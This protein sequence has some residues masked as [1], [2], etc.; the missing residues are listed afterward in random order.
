MVPVSPS[1]REMLDGL[2]DS[3]HIWVSRKGPMTRSALQMA[4]LQKSRIRLTLGT[5]R[6]SVPIVPA[7]RTR[8]A[9]LE[10]GLYKHDVQR[11][12]YRENNN[13]QI[14]GNGPG[15]FSPSGT[16]GA[17]YQGC[18]QYDLEHGVISMG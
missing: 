15:E 7:P 16:V 6:H 14:L 18:W 4:L 8:Q 5:T 12:K 2:G 1:V 3:E 13:G 10:H 9:Q 11:A 17:E